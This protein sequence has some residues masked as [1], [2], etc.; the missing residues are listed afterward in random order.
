MGILAHGA[1]QE[2]HLASH[3]LQFFQEQA[4]MDVVASQPG[5]LRQ[6]DLVDFSARDGISSAIKART[7]ETGPTVAIIEK[8]D[9]FV[10][11]PLLV[12]AVGV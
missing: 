10:L 1:I 3:A 8:G 7:L 12:L 9:E 6:Q 4:L 11:R 2:D 5:R